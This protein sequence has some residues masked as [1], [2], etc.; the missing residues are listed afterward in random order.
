M[1]SETDSFGN[2]GTATLSFT[3]AT[4][5]PTVTIGTINSATQTISGTVNPANVTAGTT[6]TI[7]DSVA[8]NSPLTPYAAGLLTANNN[9]INGLGGPARLWNPVARYRRRQFLTSAINITSVFGAAGVDFFGH[10]YTSLYINNNGNITF[11]SPNSTFTPNVITGGANNPIIAPFWADVD[12]RGGAG[13]PTGGNATGADQVFYNLDPT[14]GVLT[15][16]WDDVGYY[17]EQTNKL[18]AFEVQLISLGGGN[19]DIVFRYE[20]INWTTG[21]ASGG[22]DGLGGTPARAGYSAGDNNSADYFELPNRE[23]RRHFWRFQPPPAIRGSQALMS[24]RSS[25]G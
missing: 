18:D 22:M 21:E 3:L 23:I 12:T 16:T 13:T 17:A 1:A 15:I 24:S 11:G 4:E 2:T 25:T 7:F 5:A 6:V 20:S 9:L 8:S 14:N 10:N 19:F